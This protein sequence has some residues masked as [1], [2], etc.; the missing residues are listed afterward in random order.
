MKRYTLLLSLCVAAAAQSAAADKSVPAPAAPAPGA[1]DRYFRMKQVKINDQGMNQMPAVDLMI[2]TTWQFKGDVRW[3]G[4][5]GGCFA[6]LPAVFMHAQSEDG[7]IVFES[8]PNFT[9]QFTDDPGAQ[10]ALVQENQGG[11]KVGLKPC[12]VLRPMRA[13][14]FLRQAVIPKTRSGKR[15][16]SVDP[17][18]EFNQMVR[19]Q[20][21]L[22][23]DGAGAGGQSAVRTDA[24]RARLEYDVDGKT[25]EEWLTTV[26]VVRT[27]PSGRGANNY[28]CHALLMLSLRAPKGQLDGNDK[29]FKLIAGTIRHEPQWDAKVNAMIAKLYQA[30]QQEEAKRS[31]IVA[32]FQQHVADTIN[33]VTANQMRGANAAAFGQDQLIRGVQTFRNPATGGTFELSNQY[34]HAWLN[35]SN[36]YVM[37]E[38]PNFNPNGQLNGNWTSLQTVRPQP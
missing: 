26:V 25:I 5:V 32:A 18:P 16:V 27:F 17:L 10:R 24:A 13:E 14:D 6:D 4:G 9:W 1:S 12:P 3:G 30:K 33:E 21:G 28:D 22:G 8:I 37:S 19:R 38:D 11:V 2:P 7:S 31:A 15:V 36:E 35:G 23:P 29:L 20:L 34:D